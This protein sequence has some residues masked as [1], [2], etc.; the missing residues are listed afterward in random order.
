MLRWMSLKFKTPALLKTPLGKKQA[1]HWEK[2]LLMHVLS[3]NLDPEY[4][5]TSHKSITKDKQST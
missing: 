2:L 4:I 5:K 3:Q 1:T